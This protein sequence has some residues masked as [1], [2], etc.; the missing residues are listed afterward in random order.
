MRRSRRIPLIWM[1]PLL[2]ALIG[3]WLA[4]DTLSKRGPTIVVEFETGNGLVPGQSPLKYKDVPMGT[5]KS[6]DISRDLKKVLVTIETTHEAAPLLT[7]K[8]VFWVVKPQLFAGKVS[9]LD[10]LLSGSYVGM[11]PSTEPGKAERH[12]VGKEDPPIL[13]TS[14]PGT[15]FKLDTKRIGSISLGSPIF[16]RDIEVGA[17]LGWEL[18]DMARHVT[19]HA[20]VRAPFDQYVHDGSLW[21]DAS[22][23][24]VKLDGGGVKVQLESV[25]ALLLG[26]IAF[27]TDP[28]RKSPRS[29]P[30][31]TF[32]LYANRDAAH[33]AGFGRKLHMVSFFHGSVAGLQVGADVILHG[34]K[35]G[36][37]T[38]LGLRFDPK[39]DGIVVPV[40]YV[41][42]GDRIANIAAQGN[43]PLGTGAA[44]MIQRGFRATL[45]TSSL[46]TGTKV[47]AIKQIADAPPATI[48][49]DGDEF[50]IPSSESGGLDSITASAAA[51]LTKINRI[52][53]DAIGTTLAG[54]AKGLDDIVNGPQLKRTLQSL[55]ATMA[56]ARDFARKLDT[57]A[58]PAMGR[59]PD[60]ANQLDSAITQINRFAASLNSGYGGDS[61][62][63][64]ELDRLMPQLNEAVRS[65]R[66][67]ADLLSR[68][69]E[70]LIQGR[71][72]PGKP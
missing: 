36:E 9:G 17:V 14:I 51:L 23:V 69:P 58:G 44:E 31:Q 8:T 72:S 33:S 59:L 27:E 5:V 39:A 66:A 4:W 7:D 48:G 57:G 71:P 70:A 55:E 38:D 62:F 64:R 19:I 43:V 1:V 53:F 52:D 21:W 65:F 32:P 67:L 15:T 22:G 16:Y 12:F 50:V 20:F 13:T 56:D 18:S 28:D 24:S 40:H 30:D 61:R 47:V 45:D 54:T 68:H 2:T 11:M 29:Q 35:I 46:L 26:G 41:V 42:E 3:G 49:R 25:K 6:V 37:V 10:T 60:I 63:N 34:L